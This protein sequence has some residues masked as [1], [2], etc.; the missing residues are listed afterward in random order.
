MRIDN[1]LFMAAGTSACPNGKFYCPNAGHVPL[2]LFSSRVNDGICGKF[3]LDGEILK[4]SVHFVS[5]NPSSLLVSITV[6]SQCVDI[7][8]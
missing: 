5:F 1:I 8:G 3:F 7:H 6:L 2:L 4:F